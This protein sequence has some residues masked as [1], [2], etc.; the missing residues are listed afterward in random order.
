MPSGGGLVDV[1]ETLLRY[2][3]LI[4]AIALV[5]GVAVVVLGL[6]QGRV[7]AAESAF[8]L[9]TDRPAAGVSGIAAQFGIAIPQNGDAQGPGFYADLLR[10]PTIL[11]PILDSGVV[12]P[13]PTG[14]TMLRLIDSIPPSAG[15][16][17]V[18]R[19]YAMQRLQNRIGATAAQ[20]TGV[21]TLR[22]VDPSP[23]VAL[24]LNQ[25]MLALLNEFN[26]A[27]RRTQATDQRSFVEDRLAQARDSLR[28][29]EE[30]LRIFLAANRGYVPSSEAS[31]ERQRLERDV[32]TRSQVYLSLLQS[33]EQAK[34]EE[35]RSAPLLS[36]IQTPELPVGP[37]PRRLARKAMIGLLIGALI[38]IFLAYL[39]ES[40]RL[41]RL[42]D[43]DM[44]AALGH[45]AGDLRRNWWRPWRAALRSDPRYV[46]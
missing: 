21:V 23:Q 11:R 35:I 20:R 25:R 38:G 41:A 22:V 9:D 7:F 31:F 34:V 29:S 30:R 5:V 44:F 36:V 45:A 1:L 42:R 10:S 2:A 4:I 46:P 33:Y 24:A 43:P 28:G 27:R 26:I 3:W 32:S 18:R 19:F 37:E 39:I 12:V 14:P 15:A 8:V 40:I 17:A 16:R 13:A 6:Q